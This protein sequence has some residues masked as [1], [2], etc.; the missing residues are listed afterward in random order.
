MEKGRQ[1]EAKEGEIV[2]RQRHT[3]REEW[4]TR[5][6]VVIKETV[7]EAGTS[8]GQKSSGNTT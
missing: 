8:G 2:R 4:G 7:C 6:G 3:G 1:I 5:E